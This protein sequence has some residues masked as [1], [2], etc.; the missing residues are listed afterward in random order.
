MEVMSRFRPYAATTVFTLL[1][2]YFGVSA[3]TGERGLLTDRA[4]EA[5]LAARTAELQRL[6]A[7]TADLEQRVRLMSDV[8]LSADLVEERAKRTLGFTDPRD[9]VIRTRP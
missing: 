3:M 7:E 8:G 2:C 9:Y 1:I 4:R 6:R 5:T